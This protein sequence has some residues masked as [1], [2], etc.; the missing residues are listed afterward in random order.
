MI[1]R[2]Y[3]MLSKITKEQ[4]I[5]FSKKRLPIYLIALIILLKFGVIGLM[6]TFLFTM[7][8][9]L[10]YVSKGLV[11]LYKDYRISLRLNKVYFNQAEYLSLQRMNEALEKAVKAYQTNGTKGQGPRGAVM[12]PGGPGPTTRMSHD[13]IMTMMKQIHEGAET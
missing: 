1:K 3:P 12:P 7:F 11:N 8:F 2:L 13:E 6:Y 5:T 10:G 9:V 4:L